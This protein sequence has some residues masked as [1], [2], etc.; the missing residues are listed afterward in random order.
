MADVNLNSRS[1]CNKL[2]AV[3]KMADDLTIDGLESNSFLSVDE[4]N[5]SIIDGSFYSQPL[6]AL[7]PNSHLGGNETVSDGFFEDSLVDIPLV[8]EEQ[9]ISTEA[10]IQQTPEKS[11]NKRKKNK[12]LKPKIKPKN[13]STTANS[14]IDDA[15]EVD[16]PRKWSRKKVQIKTFE[17]EFSVIVWASGIYWAVFQFLYVCTHT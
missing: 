5:L 10:A 6:I 3:N 1:Y 9:E 17:G 7:Q 8:G 14:D 12:N 13:K 16:V 4:D 15:N 11:G 2:N